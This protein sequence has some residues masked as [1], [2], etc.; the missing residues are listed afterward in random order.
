MLVMPVD[1]PPTDDDACVAM[2]SSRTMIVG[3]RAMRAP[4]PP[5]IAPVEPQGP[6]MVLPGQTSESYLVTP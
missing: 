2:P 4:T 5:W 6:R 1:E 3:E